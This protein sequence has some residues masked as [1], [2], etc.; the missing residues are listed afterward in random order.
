M[1]MP[2]L[3]IHQEKVEDPQVLVDI[4]PFGAMEEKTENFLSMPHV[5][6][7]NYV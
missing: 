6:C 1:R 4:C 2:K 7:A 3:V 5:R